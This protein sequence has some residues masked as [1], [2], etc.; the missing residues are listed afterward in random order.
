MRLGLTHEKFDIIKRPTQDSHQNAA[1]LN[2]LVFEVL[3][4]HPFNQRAKVTVTHLIAPILTV[5]TKGFPCL[6]GITQD[7]PGETWMRL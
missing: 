1:S 2:F 5:I 7:T 3:N 6:L 4:R